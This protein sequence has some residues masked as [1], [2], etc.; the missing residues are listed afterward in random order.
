MADTVVSASELK[1]GF[2]REDESIQ[3]VTVPDPAPIDPDSEGADIRAVMT[4][5]TQNHLLVDSKTDAVLSETSILTAFTTDK[6]T[7]TLDI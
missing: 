5:L 4:Y 2:S 6:T 3:Y 1:M 7:I